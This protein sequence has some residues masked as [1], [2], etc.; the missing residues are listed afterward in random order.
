MLTRF[1]VV[2]DDA[3]TLTRDLACS[4]TGSSYIRINP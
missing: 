3:Y 1:M 2:L 4:V